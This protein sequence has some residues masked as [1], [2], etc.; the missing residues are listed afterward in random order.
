MVAQAKI[1]IFGLTHPRLVC[2]PWMP[3]KLMMNSQFMYSR[4]YHTS[5]FLF[6]NCILNLP[7]LKSTSYSCIFWKLNFNEFSNL[8]P[9]I[10][11]EVPRTC[12][13]CPELCLLSSM[14]LHDLIRLW[15]NL[16]NASLLIIIIIWCWSVLY[17]SDIGSESRHTLFSI[18]TQRSNV[19]NSLC[20]LNQN[21]CCLHLKHLTDSEKYF[22]I[23]DWRQETDRNRCWPR[24][25]WLLSK[26]LILIFSRFKSLIVP[27]LESEKPIK[28]ERMIRG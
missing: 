6:N 3:T 27:H 2:D 9:S 25:C 16:R 17:Q 1:S 18:T 28:Q 23:L 8:F 15:R 24:L 22:Q 4:D 11:Q 13:K 26:S 7:H 5:Y 12:E 19:N 21:I 14:V 10:N 20:I